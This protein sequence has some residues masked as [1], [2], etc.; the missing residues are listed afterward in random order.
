MSR[1]GDEIRE[2]MKRQDG[3]RRS[4]C[5]AAEVLEGWPDPID[6]WCAFST[7]LSLGRDEARELHY[8]LN[9]EGLSSGCAEYDRKLDRTAM[10]TFILK[11]REQILRS[12]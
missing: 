6:S 2:F 3:L 4:L 9:R 12:C 8:R 11:H 7:A 10:L 1:C 5:R